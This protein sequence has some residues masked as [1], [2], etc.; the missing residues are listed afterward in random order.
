MSP[1][2][3][4]DINVADPNSNGT[5]WMIQYDGKGKRVFHTTARFY[6]P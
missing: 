4:R 1:F 6:K 3:D 5:R 2:G